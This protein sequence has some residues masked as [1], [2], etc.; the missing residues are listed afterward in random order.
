ML[1]CLVQRETPE[2]WLSLFIPKWVPGI[3]HR[4]LGLHTL[5]LCL[6]DHPIEPFLP[7]LSVGFTGSNKK[8]LFS[9]IKN[10]LLLNFLC[11]LNLPEVICTVKKKSMW[12]RIKWP[13]L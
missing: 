2:N 3:E 4:S 6:W 5:F 8:S 1:L 12:G 13:H 9:V 7:L 11:F 10:L